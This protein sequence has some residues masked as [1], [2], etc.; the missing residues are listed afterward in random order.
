MVS[1]CWEA[2]LTPPA[3]AIDQISNLNCL[4]KGARLASPKPYELRTFTGSRAGGGGALDAAPTHENR[5]AATPVMRTH[6]IANSG[7]VRAGETFM[8]P[9][10]SRSP[11]N[12]CRS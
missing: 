7:R 5:V 12:E 10:S 11:G 2:G 6:R 1:E 3:Q 4:G 8:V 9:G